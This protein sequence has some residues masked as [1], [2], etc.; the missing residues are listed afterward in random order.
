MQLTK[1]IDDV[2]EVFK[3][4]KHRKATP[5]FCIGVAA[6]NIKLTSSL[7]YFLTPKQYYCDKCGYV[8]IV[9]L[10]LEEDKDQKEKEETGA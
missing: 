9:V 3:S 7:A 1:K 4:M 8:G 6:Q 10:E 5:I 2:R